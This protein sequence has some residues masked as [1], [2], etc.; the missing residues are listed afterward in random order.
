MKTLV[1]HDMTGEKKFILKLTGWELPYF[2]EIPDPV[3]VSALS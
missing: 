3:T 1:L 2:T